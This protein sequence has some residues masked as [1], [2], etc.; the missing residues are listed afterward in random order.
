MSGNQSLDRGLGILDL[1]DRAPEPIGIREI[2][3]D[4]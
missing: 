4:M 2:A 3:R 1:L